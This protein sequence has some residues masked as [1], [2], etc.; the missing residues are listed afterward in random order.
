M[1]REAER[2]RWAVTALDVR[3]GDR[4]LEIGCGHGVALGLVCARLGESGHVTAIDR[5]AAMV[6]AAVRRNEE[7]IAAGRLTVEHVALADASFPPGAFGKIF[8]AHVGTF[9][10]G[11][12]AAARRV[13]EWIAPGGALY[14]FT[15]PLAAGQT[16]A[17]GEQVSAALVRS[18]FAVRSVTAGDTAPRPTVCVT[19]VPVQAA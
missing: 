19:A 14:L 18:G 8:A 2:H 13:T 10:R 1:A 7:H 17:V 11:P 5:S 4:L 16:G 9:W 15:Q 6:R 3:P 12:F